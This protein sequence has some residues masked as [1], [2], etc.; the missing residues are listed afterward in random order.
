MF[1]RTASTKHN[2][3]RKDDFKR[4]KPHQYPV[5]SAMTSHVSTHTSMTSQGR[6][7]SNM[8]S[9]STL[10]TS[11]AAKPPRMTS[12]LHHN[13]S[14]TSQLRHQNLYGYP[15]NTPPSSMSTYGTSPPNGQDIMP[16]MR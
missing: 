1:N 13:N 15:T 5:P 3:Q 11:Q 10:I 7:S 4:S 14:M 12:Q 6:L 16:N 9:H 2:V 8:M